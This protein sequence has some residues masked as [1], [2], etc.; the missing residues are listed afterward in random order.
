[1]KKILIALALLGTGMVFGAMAAEI[2]AVG[3][4]PRSRGGSPEER[5]LSAPRSGEG[6]A[7][8][9]PGPVVAP[10]EYRYTGPHTH[11]NLTIY[12]IHGNETIKPHFLSLQ[13]ALERE[14]AVVHETDQVGQLAIENRSTTEDL[15]IQSG[16]IVKGGQ[17]DRVLQYDMMIPPGSGKVPLASFCVEQGRWSP[18]GKENSRKFTAPAPCFGSCGPSC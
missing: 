15:F 7:S 2:L 8:D 5:F 14:L 4:N 12:L 6:F 13:E 18:R 3:Y 11:E 10:G 16:D 1:M 17:Q 9:E